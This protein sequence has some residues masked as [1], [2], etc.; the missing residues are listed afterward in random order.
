MKSYAPTLICNKCDVVYADGVKYEW[1]PKCNGSVDPFDPT[2]E[3]YVC[4]KCEFM[5][6]K[7]LPR[8]DAHRAKCKSCENVRMKKISPAGVHYK[9]QSFSKEG[10]LSLHRAAENL[11]FYIFPAVTILAAL[12]MGMGFWDG[13]RHGEGWNN[14]GIG[15]LLVMGLPLIAYAILFLYVAGT[16]II[17]SSGFFT[18]FATAKARLIRINHGLEHATFNVL[19]E[20]DLPMFSGHADEKG[21]ELVGPVSAE[22][23]GFAFIEA[24]RRI[25]K[26]EHDLVTTVHCGTRVGI[27]GLLFLSVPLL[28]FILMLKNIITPAQM[29]GFAVLAFFFGFIA[30]KRLSL[31]AQKYV[32][33]STTFDEASIIEIKKIRP[34]AH[35]IETS[36]KVA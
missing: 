26:G 29:M 12:F 31:L 22:N 3:I 14:P 23:V 19:Q 4:P 25:K 15:V 33:T 20:N 36:V 2:K 34:G 1:C 9:D 11:I 13:Y 5:I 21:F 32:T 30:K 27:F 7:N 24:V 17:A 10:V 8:E 16:E 6:N 28:L 35:Y 18:L